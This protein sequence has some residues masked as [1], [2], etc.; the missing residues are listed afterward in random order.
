MKQPKEDKSVSIRCLNTSQHLTPWL[1]GCL[2]EV[3]ESD[4]N[5][6]KNQDSKNYGGMTKSITVKFPVASYFGNIGRYPGWKSDSSFGNL[7]LRVKDF[8]ETAE[9]PVSDYRRVA[10]STGSEELKAIV[11]RSVKEGY[12]ISSHSK[13][14]LFNG[15]V[16]NL[17]SSMPYSYLWKKEAPFGTNDENVFMEFRIYPLD[18]IVSPCPSHVK[19]FIL[20]VYTRA[21]SNF[22][23]ERM[24][25]DV[26]IYSSDI[27][28]VNYLDGE[29]KN[30]Q[31]VDRN[32]LK[33]SYNKSISITE[34]LDRFKRGKLQ[35]NNK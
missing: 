2:G 34:C 25:E 31:K 16:Y 12:Y 28:Y 3:K 35:P 27:D 7:S 10:L 32:Y 18:I 8:V 21:V 33:N 20:C 24:V 14:S 6:L 9:I 26:F 23:S 4:L 22:F 5:R 1:E 11:E 30:K 15:E 13:L 17:I 29:D 19:G